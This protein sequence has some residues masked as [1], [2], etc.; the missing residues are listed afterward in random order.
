MHP[1]Q[2]RY[3][4]AADR[5]AREALVAEG[6]TPEEAAQALLDDEAARGA[7]RDAPVGY[8]AAAPTG[9]VSWGLGL[10]AYLPIPLLSLVI[11]G[12]AMACAYP[13]QRRRSPVAAENARNA[14]NWGLTLVLVCVL[15]IGAVVALALALA[16]APGDRA[17]IP[18]VLIF[19]LGLAHLVMVVRGMVR[20]RRGEVLAT[21][22]AIPFIRG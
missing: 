7:G 4:S 18:F 20:A 3:E 14:A 22:L 19:P 11:A 17:L 1:A 15:M 16:P 5:R 9:T 8:G 6:F 12:V 2:P 10:L 13:S 21:R